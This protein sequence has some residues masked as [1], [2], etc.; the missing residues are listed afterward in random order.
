MFADRNIQILSMRILG[1]NR[2]V[3]RMQ[4]RSAGGS[5]FTAVYFGQ[6]EELLSFLR[7]K[8]GSGALEQALAGKD[9][10]MLVSFVYYP[11]LNVY[12]GR[13]SIQIVVKKY[14]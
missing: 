3:C 8:Y 6:V 5:N 11:E 4:I 13:E 14:R 2:N 9:S 1:K 7:E 12:N 10:G